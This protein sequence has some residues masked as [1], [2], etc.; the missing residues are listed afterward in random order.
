[1]WASRASV[2]DAL[3]P[4]AGTFVSLFSP[5]NKDASIKRGAMHWFQYIYMIRVAVT[6]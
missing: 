3:K 5:Q 4:K 1:M 2:H 6:K